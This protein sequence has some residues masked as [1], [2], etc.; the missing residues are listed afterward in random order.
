MGVLYFPV[1]YYV[2]Q[3]VHDVCLLLFTATAEATVVRRRSLIT[4]HLITI[5]LIAIVVILQM[6]Q[7]DLTRLVEMTA[8]AAARRT[9]RSRQIQT[10]LLC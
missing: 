3:S 2:M 4:I 10:T 7:R 9:R 1:R 5:H 8:A 6:V